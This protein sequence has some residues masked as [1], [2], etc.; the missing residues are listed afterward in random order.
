MFITKIK[1]AHISITFEIY[2]QN[3]Q[4]FFYCKSLITRVD[5]S[6]LE[7]FLKYSLNFCYP[8]VWH[9]DTFTFNI[10]IHTFEVVGVIMLIV[11]S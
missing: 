11:A 8:T 2:F 1:S 6:K 4:A 3:L 10:T 9:N 5:V 7:I